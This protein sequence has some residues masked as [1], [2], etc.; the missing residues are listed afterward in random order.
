MSRCQRSAGLVHV[1]PPL[2][3]P[4]GAEA[5]AGLES[6]H[7]AF[8]PP[9]SHIA[10]TGFCMCENMRERG[11]KGTL[12]SATLQKH[13]LTPDRGSRKGQRCRPRSQPLRLAFNESPSADSTAT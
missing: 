10:R 8:L 4:G 13:V 1:L 7:V 12:R 11:E 9:R 3:I 6:C 5:G 2:S